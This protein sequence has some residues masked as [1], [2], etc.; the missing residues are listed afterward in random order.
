MNNSGAPQPAGAEKESNSVME[1][2]RILGRLPRKTNKASEHEWKLC[3]RLQDA[4][5]RKQFTGAEEEELA[6]MENSARKRTEDSVMET[7]R[8]LGWHAPD[9]DG[10]HLV[11]CQVRGEQPLGSTHPLPH[12]FHN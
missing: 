3:K 5:R 7:I 10:N 4:R 9:D 11:Q 6:A 1:S 12:N 2:I 8:I